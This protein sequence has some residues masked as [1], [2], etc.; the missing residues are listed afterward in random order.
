M[1]YKQLQSG[2]LLSAYEP[3][4]F[5][6]SIHDNG[7]GTYTINNPTNVTLADWYTNY[8]SY[9]KKYTC[10]DSNTTCAAPRYT[11]ATT[12]T[13]YTYINA[14][15]KIMIGKT[16]SGLTLTDTLLV[17][18]DELVINS[19]NYSDYKYTC[20]TD[21]DTCTESTLRMISRYST[22]G[23]YY[24]LNHYWGSSVT[25]DGTNYTLVDPIEIENY[26]N[27]NNLS[28]HHYMC[29][30]Y[31]LK[32]CATVAYVYYYTG[33]GTMYYITLR[34]GVTTVGKALEDMFTKNTTNSIMKSGVDA[35][36]KHYLLE[37]YDDY[38]EDTIFCNDRSQHNAS[39][40]GWNPDGGIPASYMYFYGAS[41]LSCPND[42]DKF[43][44]GNNKAQLT[45]KVGLMSYPE[46]SLLDNSNA[47]KTGQWYWL[48]SPYYFDSY[49][50]GAYDFIVDSSGGMYHYSVNQG[51]GV[52]PAV[53]LTPGIEYSDGDG[54]M[55]NPYKVELGS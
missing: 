24:A 36:Y 37:D 5:G 45:Y 15:E 39:T 43:S 35:W 17:R 32:T 9:K 22:T 41:D 26:N 25:W 40:N 54:S 21:S 18:K 34:D 14:G 55:A 7:D 53:S 31:G 19:S 30:S 13:N 28:T 29:V 16:R 8:A 49:S 44:V 12:S 38:I 27:L 23:Y 42:T 46:M 47:L 3:I 11:T 48:A 6:D 20:N 1:Y 52:R 4:V 51:G 10:N 2:N 33:S 50:Y